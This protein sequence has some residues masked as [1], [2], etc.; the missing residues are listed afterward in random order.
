MRSNGNTNL[1]SDRPGRTPVTVVS[2]SFALTESGKRGQRLRAALP[3][4][5]FRIGRAAARA[6][7]ARVPVDV[8]PKL[9]ASFVPS[10]LRYQ[11]TLA[12]SRAMPSASTC[13]IAT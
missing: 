12:P 5:V 1:H 13:R 9:R 8:Q 4:A 7:L 2:V 3:D 10:G 6:R 11:F